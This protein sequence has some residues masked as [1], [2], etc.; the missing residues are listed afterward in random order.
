MFQTASI[1]TSTGYASADYALWPSLSLLILMFLM[2]VGASAGST[3]GG[4]KILRLKIAYEIVRQE[5]GRIVQPRSVRSIRMN[6]K[7]FL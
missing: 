7:L 5:I 3:S 4:L 1:G 6:G 2:I